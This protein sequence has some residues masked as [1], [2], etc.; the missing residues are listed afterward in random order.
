MIN[1][2]ELFVTI[3]SARTPRK[4]MHDYLKTKVGLK[5]PNDRRLPPFLRTTGIIDHAGGL[6]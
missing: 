4:F 3:Q 6:G 5:G 1:V 2:G